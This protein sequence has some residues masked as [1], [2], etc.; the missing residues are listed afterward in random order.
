MLPET[1]FSIF[2][3][4]YVFAEEPI[5]A[6]FAYLAEKGAFTDD[7]TGPLRENWGALVALP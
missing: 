2:V 5:C 7:R 6:E 1:P 3:D 4:V